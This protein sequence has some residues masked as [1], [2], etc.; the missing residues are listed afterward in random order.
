MQI[1]PTVGNGQN[2][3]KNQKKKDEQDAAKS[4]GHA[5][6]KETAGN[7][8]KV[9]ERQGGG[10]VVTASGK[11]IVCYKSTHWTSKEKFKN[12]MKFEAKFKKGRTYRQYGYLVG[13]LQDRPPSLQVIPPHGA[14]Y[15]QDEIDEQVES[16]SNKPE[17]SEGGD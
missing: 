14:I 1:S 13:H 7:A 17:S 3:A 15:D 16:Y 8:D 5:A 10:Y 6:K 9:E 4:P 2:N 12:D 11:E